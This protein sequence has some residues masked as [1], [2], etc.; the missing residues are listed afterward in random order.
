M[1]NDK[2]CV[3]GTE[4]EKKIGRWGTYHVIEREKSRLGP[5]FGVRT[6][7]IDREMT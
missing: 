3:Y 7:K 5:E 6:S 4:G 2:V 1:K